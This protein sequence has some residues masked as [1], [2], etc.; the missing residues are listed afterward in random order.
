[1]ENIVFLA[2]PRRDKISI[3]HIIFFSPLKNISCLVLELLNSTC[4]NVQRSTY[5]ELKKCF[6]G[7]N[8]L[9]SLSWLGQDL[10]DDH[11]VR[12]QSENQWYHQ[13]LKHFPVFQVPFRK[14]THL[15]HATHIFD[16]RLFKK[17]SICIKIKEGAVC[18]E[19]FADFK[20]ST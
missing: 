5:I 10:E 20:F 4:F 3:S 11:S 13:W 9:D 19:I 7:K 14:E 12:N 16:L 2:D 8:E 17:L 6:E 15:I 18:T 1:M